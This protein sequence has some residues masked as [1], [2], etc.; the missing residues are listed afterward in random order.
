MTKAATR[1]P[2]ALIVTVLLL[3]A[4]TNSTTPV[5]PAKKFAD[6]VTRAFPS[7]LR[8]LCYGNVVNDVD[9]I[10][11]DALASCPEGTSGIS[12][13]D[14]DSFWTPCPAMQPVRITYQCQK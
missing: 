13:L 8:A 1:G 4:C 12:I 7:D 10:R 9:D 11:F 14:Q 6:P 5:P 2:L 3:G